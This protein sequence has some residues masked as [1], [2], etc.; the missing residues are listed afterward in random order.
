MIAAKGDAESGIGSK[1]ALF[2]NS[3]HRTKNVQI[4]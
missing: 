4:I 1:T 3:H 2:E